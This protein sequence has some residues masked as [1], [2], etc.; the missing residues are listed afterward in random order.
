[1][2]RSLFASM[3]LVVSAFL[4]FPGRVLAAQAL[5][6]ACDVGQYNDN[7][8]VVR[9]AATGTSG[10]WI[11]SASAWISRY[12]YSLC[13]GSLRPWVTGSGA[14]PAIVGPGG[15]DI[16]QVG[17]WKCGDGRVCGN[18]MHTNQLDFFYASGATGDI[19]HAPWPTNISLAD[20]AASHTFTVRLAYRPD[21]SRVWEYVIDD[22]VRAS[23]PD[24][25]WRSWNRQRAQVG[26]EQWNCGDQM[27][28]RTADG[29][30]PGNKQKFR[31]LTWV[32]GGVTH[33]GGFDGP[34]QTGNNPY[35][36]WIYAQAYNS[37][38]FDV[39][40]WNHAQTCSAA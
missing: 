18:G 16:V 22:Q 23:E 36:P 6:G 11:T 38:D 8:W 34:A 2:K 25:A 12:D 15:D 1:M 39:W 10:P 13:T 29:S 9:N 17:Y 33:A 21:G 20:T 5:A 24:G 4:P 28:G 40:T 14:W 31:S 32:A 35:Y 19:N 3:L 37:S 26:T 27:G 7:T 30:D